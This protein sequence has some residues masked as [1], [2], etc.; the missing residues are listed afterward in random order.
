MIR[1]RNTSVISRI[2]CPN[3]QPNTK[4]ARKRLTCLNFDTEK[5]SSGKYVKTLQKKLKINKTAFRG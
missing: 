4:T 3:K 5:G 2:A 1:L